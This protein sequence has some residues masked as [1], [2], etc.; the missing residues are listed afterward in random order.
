MK[1]NMRYVIERCCY[2]TFQRDKSLSFENKSPK[3]RLLASSKH[4]FLNLKEI[5]FCLISDVDHIKS[6]SLLQLTTMNVE[7]NS[8]NNFAKDFILR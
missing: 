3:S 1:L 4:P 5:R 6:L 2:F 7:C 8:P